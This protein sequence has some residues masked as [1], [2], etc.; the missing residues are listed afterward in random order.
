MEKEP[1][2]KK[3]PENDN[4]KSVSKTSDNKPSMEQIEAILQARAYKYTREF[5]DCSLCGLFRGDLLHLIRCGWLACQ[6]AERKKVEEPISCVEWEQ[7]ILRLKQDKKDMERWLEAEYKKVDTL[8][9]EIAS[10]KKKLS[11]CKKAVIANMELVDERENQLASEKKLREH[12]IDWTLLPLIDEW[13]CQ[14]GQI[15]W[16]DSRKEKRI[17]ELRYYL[18]GRIKELREGVKGGKG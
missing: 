1:Q 12:C 16:K 4:K 6:E 15:F 8:E 13:Y 10:L 3:N 7:E 11:G 18:E 14:V 17:A 9:A 5:T 2:L